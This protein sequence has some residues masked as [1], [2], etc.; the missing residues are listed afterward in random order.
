MTGVSTGWLRGGLLIAG[1]IA[2][3]YDASPFS[4]AGAG[5]RLAAGLRRRGHA[6][7]MADPVFAAE[8]TRRRTPDGKYLLGGNDDLPSAGYS[9]HLDHRRALAGYGWLEDAALELSRVRAVLPVRSLLAVFDSATRGFT[10]QD[11]WNL[12]WRLAGR[13]GEQLLELAKLNSC[14]ADSRSSRE[15]WVEAL[16]EHGQAL[17]DYSVQDGVDELEPDWPS[18]NEEG[19]FLREESWAAAEAREGELLAGAT[20]AWEW[21]AAHHQQLRHVSFAM[22]GHDARP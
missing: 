19:D 17:V 11:T 12:G 9:E 22:R 8:E 4:P 18:G 7:A 6:K 16:T 2:M 14:P 3:A 5:S 13:T 21:I 1:E 20:R 10:D 15:G